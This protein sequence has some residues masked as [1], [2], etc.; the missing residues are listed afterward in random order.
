VNPGESQKVK[1]LKVPSVSL[2]EV[3]EKIQIKKL[4]LMSADL[5]GYGAVAFRSNNWTNPKCRP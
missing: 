4:N 5:E 3:C 2:K 1:K